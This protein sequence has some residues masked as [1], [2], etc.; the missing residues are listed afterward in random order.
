MAQGVMQLQR[1]YGAIPVV[2]GIGPA[3]EQ[4]ADSLSRMIDAA[5][6][7]IN[8][9]GSY[10]RRQESLTFQALPKAEGMIIGAKSQ[11]AIVHDTKQRRTWEVKRELVEEFLAAIHNT[12]DYLGFGSCR[13]RD[14]C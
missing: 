3:A 12:L 11:A 5:G 9:A 2:R 13:R 7:E 1:L 8:P 6:A 4:M 14:T 10:L